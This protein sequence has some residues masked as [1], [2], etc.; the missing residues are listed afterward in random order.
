MRE[1]SPKLQG[2][3]FAS[4]WLACRAPPKRAPCGIGRRP[5]RTVA[6]ARAD[7][8]RSGKHGEHWN[9]QRSTPHPGRRG[10]LC[11]RTRGHA[12][13]RWPKARSR[14]APR[15]ISPRTALR[16]A[17]RST[18]RP[19]PRR[20]NRRSRPA[21][22]TPARR[23]WAAICR[24]VMNFSQE[25]YA[26]AF[27]PKAGTPGVGWAISDDKVR[28]RS[29]RRRCAR[30][31]RAP[32]GATS[33]RSTSPAAI[34][35]TDRRAAARIPFRRRP[36]A[37]PGSAARPADCRLQGLCFDAALADMPTARSGRV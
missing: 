17:P 24:V 23:T 20:T 6:G 18:R 7:V 21:A 9:E 2:R 33:A 28:R 12:G 35:T 16:S 11:G 10:S 3:G 22:S 29:V 34:R 8:F 14:L 27:D 32:A 30:R 37:R 25:C 19:P 26:L 4:R 13:R 36:E 15:E 5:P 31:P 1:T